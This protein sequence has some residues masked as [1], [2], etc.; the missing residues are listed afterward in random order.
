VCV[1]ASIIQNA[2]NVRRIILLPVPC[3]TLP[4]FSALFHVRHYFREKKLLN[5]KYVLIF[6]ITCLKHFL[7]EEE[8]IEI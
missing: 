5:R 7:C 6:Y 2:K 3:L 1:L 4:Y 8:L